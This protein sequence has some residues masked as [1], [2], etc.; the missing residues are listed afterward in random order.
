MKRNRIFFFQMI[1]DS[2]KDVRDLHIISGD[3]IKLEYLDH[4]AFLPMDFKTNIFLAYFMTRWARIQ[5]YELLD[6][7]QIYVDTDSILFVDRDKRSQTNC[8][9]VIIWENRR[10]RFHRKMDIS[11]ISF[12]E[13]PKTTPTKLL[14]EKKFVA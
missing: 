1:S 7:T 4:P 11:H 2:R 14:P 13:D 8:L 10:T 6:I 12:L 9:L 3:I 5:L